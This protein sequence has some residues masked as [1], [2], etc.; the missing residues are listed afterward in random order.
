MGRHPSAS[1]T[2]GQVQPVLPGGITS[3]ISARATAANEGMHQAIKHEMERLEG[4]LKAQE[5]SL[6]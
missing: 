3:S 1:S 5:E 4:A 6:L 2:W